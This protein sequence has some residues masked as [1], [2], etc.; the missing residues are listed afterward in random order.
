MLVDSNCHASWNQIVRL[1]FLLGFRI[2]SNEHRN[3]LF[4]ECKTIRDDICCGQKHLG[5][6]LREL[7]DDYIY[8]C[9]ITIQP[10]NREM[11]SNGFFSSKCRIDDRW[12][13]S[14]IMD[15]INIE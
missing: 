4:T 10:D 14:I 13:N 1:S 9:L 3:G 11:I 8:A 5:S 15:E 7:P 12:L 2:L 6:S